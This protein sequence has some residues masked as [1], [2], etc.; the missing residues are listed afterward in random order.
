MGA[1]SVGGMN[2]EPRFRTGDITGLRGAL[3]TM[4]AVESEADAIERVRA[5][6]ELKAAAVAAQARA[7][8]TLH[9]LRYDAEAERGV[10]AEKRCRGLG[11]EVGLARRESPARGSRF[12]SLARTL[13]DDMPCALAGLESGAVSEEKAHT[14]HRETSWLSAEKRRLVDELMA[15]R[16]DRVGVRRLAAEARA[17]AQRLDQ[18]AAV[19][20]VERCEKERRVSVRP[21]PGGMAYLTALLPL[22]QA[23]AAY[24]NLQKTAATLVGTGEAGERTAGQVAADLLVERVTGQETADAVPVEVH[25]V[26]TD[27]TLLADG[28]VPGWVTGHGPVPAGAA[29]RMLADPDGSVFLRRLYTAPGSG[30]LVGMDSRRREFSGVLRRMIVVRDDTC[31]TPFCDAPIRHIDHA[32]PHRDGGATDF[33]NA[34][35][36]CAACNYAK[37][38]PG[39]RHEADP[40]RLTVTTPTGARYEAPTPPL[41]GGAHRQPRTAPPC[42]GEPPSQSA[43]MKFAGGEPPPRDAPVE[44]TE[45]QSV[46][47]DDRISNDQMPTNRVVRL[48][49]PRSTGTGSD[50]RSGQGSDIRSGTSSTGHIRGSGVE[51]TV[52]AHLTAHSATARTTGQLPPIDA[53]RFPVLAG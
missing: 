25:L 29:R 8:A 43:D 12:L 22:R 19:E 44:S 53:Y 23:V 18:E 24:A 16:L 28:D 37:E 41:I 48:I 11:A 26:M 15:D 42:R 20:H 10:P 39:W 47:A 5:L 4:V 45:P 7:A 14:L 2:E 38:N 40:D 46:G 31:R 13:L 27:S 9:S 21:A 51:K 30:G 3:T 17:H 36:L 50:S 34:S 52:R 35:G 6:E 49:R 1:D 33:R 32:R